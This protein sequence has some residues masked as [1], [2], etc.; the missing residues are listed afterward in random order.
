MMLVSVESGISIGC[1][2]ADRIE[3]VVEQTGIRRVGQGGSS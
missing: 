2:I 1:I 3:S